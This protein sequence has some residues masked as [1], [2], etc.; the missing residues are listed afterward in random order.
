MNSGTAKKLRKTI[1]YD[2]KGETKY[3][4]LYRKVNKKIVDTDAI[5]CTGKREEYL[6]LKKEYKNTKG[7]N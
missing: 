4:T 6:N 3:E 2:T 5:K 1:G 7:D